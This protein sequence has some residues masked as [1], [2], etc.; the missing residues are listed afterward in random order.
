MSRKGFTLVELLAVVIIIG[1]VIV[2]ITPTVKNLLSDSRD[3]LSK[4][5]Y[6]M[7][8]SAS[9]KYMIEHADLLSEDNS[10]AAVYVD[11]LID[12]GIIDNDNVIDPKTKNELDGCVVVS[13]NSEFNQYEYNYREDCSITVTFDPEGGT[14]SQSSMKV[15]IGKSYGEL[16]VPTRNGYIFKGWN[17]KNLFN[18][19]NVV[20]LAL[21]SSTPKFISNA[22]YRGYYIQ[23]EPG[24]VFSLSRNE[25]TNNRFKVVFATEKPEAA[26]LFFEG[27]QLY[28]YYDSLEIENIVVPSNANYLFI[29]LS[30]QADSLPTNLQLEEGSVATEYEPYYVVRDVKVTQL[31]DH[32]LH[33]V[34]E[35]ES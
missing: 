17:G 28:A 32:T 30:T 27:A 1:L 35:A 14:V 33:A 21:N 3:S 8:I 5:Q 22:L 10:F 24:D 20:N 11:D 9:K 23:C 6:D 4:Q 2:I 19:D 18:V 31:S 15:L 34:W 29:Y 25:I 13:Y 7:I 26:V 12:E 16:P